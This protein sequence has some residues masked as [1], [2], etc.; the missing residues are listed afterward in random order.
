M[1]LTKVVLATPLTNF[2]MRFALS[3]LLISLSFIMMFSSPNLGYFP[4]LWLSSC[5]SLACERGR[6]GEREE[7]RE[8]A[9]YF[10]VCYFFLGFSLRAFPLILLIFPTAW[11]FALPL[12]ANE[13]HLC[14]PSPLFGQRQK[15]ILLLLLHPESVNWPSRCW[16]QSA[17]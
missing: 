1:E 13:L 16:L 14:S 4:R 12:A 2:G 7:E 11:N 3:S 9:T 15:R 5:D 8:R 17:L 10:W 6:K